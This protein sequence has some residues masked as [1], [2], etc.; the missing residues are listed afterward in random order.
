MENTPPNKAQVRNKWLRRIVINIP[1]GLL[2]C[3]IIFGVGFWALY[4]PL[5]ELLA[6][7]PILPLAHFPTT[8][9]GIAL[10]VFSSLRGQLV[11]AITAV[12]VGMGLIVL[13]MWT[14]ILS[15]SI[16]NAAFDIR[17]SIF[18]ILV[19]MDIGILMGIGFRLLTSVLDTEVRDETQ[20]MQTQH[21][22][23]LVLVVAKHM[24]LPGLFISGSF[25]GIDGLLFG[26]LAGLLAGLAT[27]GVD[28]LHFVTGHHVFALPITE[29][30]TAS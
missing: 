20:W 4:W 15:G 9:A 2:A 11:A 25:G 24:L 30:Q 22:R 16:M 14:G 8:F 5:I 28:L 12:A 18:D 23:Q 1:L 13:G 6:W 10:V 7:G 27:G 3:A 19:S 17:M 21:L 26:V 29:N